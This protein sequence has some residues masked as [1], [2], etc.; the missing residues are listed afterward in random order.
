MKSREPTTNLIIVVRRLDDTP[1]SF[2]LIIFSSRFLRFLRTA[3]F[4]RTVFS[5]L[6]LETKTL[7]LSMKPVA[8]FTILPLSH[9]SP[10]SRFLFLFYFWIW[11]GT[12][13]HRM[14]R[15]GRRHRK[16]PEKQNQT[17]DPMNTRRAIKIPFRRHF[18]VEPQLSVDDFVFH[19]IDVSAASSANSFAQDSLPHSDTA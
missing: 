14:L 19:A 15:S 5:G 8:P 4:V 3:P 1:F 18:F 16:L 12:P 13:F 6:F 9:H 17:I 2:R 11:S 10:F 7:A